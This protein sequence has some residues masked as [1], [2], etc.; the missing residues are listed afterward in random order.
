MWPDSG[1]GGLGWGAGQRQEA[2]TLAKGPK[3]QGHQQLSQNRAPGWQAEPGPPPDTSTL[4]LKASGSEWS[5]EAR[6]SGE[7]KGDQ[8]DGGGQG[9]EGMVKC[10]HL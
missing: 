1:W 7:N 3:A 10:P 4:A 2:R 8:G 9:G 5:W 6:E